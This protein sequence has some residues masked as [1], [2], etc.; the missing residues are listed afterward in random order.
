FEHDLLDRFLGASLLR[1][2]LT[3]AEPRFDDLR[4]RLACD[5]LFADLSRQGI[6]GVALLRDSPIE[7]PGIGV[8]TAP[9]LA[10]SP[11]RDLVVGVHGPLTP[12]YASDTRIQDAKEYG[13]AVSVLLL[14]EIVISRNLRTAT[15][16]VMGAL[17][18]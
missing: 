10:R 2:L 5:R 15:R 13:T 11:Q 6:E 9:I 12:D 8:V 18:K 4:V 3:G 17:G 7:V 14:D 16:Q 1:Y